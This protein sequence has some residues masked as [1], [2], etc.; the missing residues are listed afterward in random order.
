M[1][2]IY[3]TCLLLQKKKPLKKKLSETTEHIQSEENVTKEISLLKALIF[4]V[5]GL[6]LIVGGSK[7]VVNSANQMLKEGN[8]NADTEIHLLGNDVVFTL[9][10]VGY[11]L[12][13]G[14]I[15]KSR[16]ESQA[17]SVLAWMINHGKIKTDLGDRLFYAPF[18]YADDVTVQEPIQAQ[19]QQATEKQRIEKPTKEQK[20]VDSVKEEKPKDLS[21]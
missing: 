12:E 4:T 19:V 9:A 2:H 11:K 7:F 5:I 15:V 18:V 8:F 16:D 3:F 1:Q 10:D 17:P 14:K 20:P 21:K 6:V 13:N